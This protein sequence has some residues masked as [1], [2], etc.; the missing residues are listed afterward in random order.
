LKNLTK[1]NKK[2]PLTAVCFNGLAWDYQNAEVNIFFLSI[3]LFLSNFSVYLFSSVLKT[4]TGA[5][6][7][8]TQPVD[9]YTMRKNI[10]ILL[11]TI[12]FIGCSKSND[13]EK[14]FINSDYDCWVI[15]SQNYPNYTFW[16]FNKDKTSDNLERKE[17]GDFENF[18]VDGDLVI[19]PK[20]WK[21]SSDSILTW[22]MHKYD[23]VNANE[24][25]IVLMAENKENHKQSHLFLIRENK[26]T[27]RKGAYYFEQKRLKNSEKYISK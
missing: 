25:V 8:Y 22:G 23:V 17:N 11:L 26:K 12:C 10:F 13:L 14:K 18:N 24:N 27:Q 20:N 5:S 2:L 15:Y 9:H 19:G 21:V 16:R 7:S 3:A 1:L 4:A 6:D